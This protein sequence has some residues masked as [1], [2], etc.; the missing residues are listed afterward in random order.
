MVLPSRASLQENHSI[1]WL[2]P[3]S[4]PTI[5]QTKTNNLASSFKL[6]EVAK[7]WKT[8]LKLGE[9]LSLIKFNPSRSNPSQLEPSGW[10]N[11]TQV[12][13]SWNLGS[14]WQY[15][16]AT[17][18][19]TAHALTSGVSKIMGSRPST[20]TLYTLDAGAPNDRILL[21]GRREVERLRPD[22]YRADWRS[23]RW[24]AC[25]AGV[26]VSTRWNPG[27]HLGEPRKPGMS[28]IEWAREWDRTKMA[29]KTNEADE[30]G[31]H[32]K[33]ACFAG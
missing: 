9:N 21:K 23:G 4:H 14:S 31:S 18:L 5:K 13:P 11:D 22:H 30:S 3:R 25:G 33:N 28:T 15:R 20:M 19:G 10:P 16:L 6:A 24:L 32:K 8:W 2:R 27:R 17:V 29:A 12:G 1:V 7:R 26:L